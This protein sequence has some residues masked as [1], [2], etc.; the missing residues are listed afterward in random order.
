[1]AC[2]DF[3]EQQEEHAEIKSL[4]KPDTNL[5]KLPGES[6]S[7]EQAKSP[8][9]RLR[10]PVFHHRRASFSSPSEPHS[11]PEMLTDN[12]KAAESQ[13]RELFDLLYRR[14]TGRECH[15]VMICS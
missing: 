13:E 2:K 4:L 15:R 14:A 5:G 9:K 1:M 3:M 7:V 8:A 11:R 6:T 12:L 10:S